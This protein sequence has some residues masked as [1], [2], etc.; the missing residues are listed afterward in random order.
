MA[1]TATPAERVTKRRI[2]ATTTLAITDLP[3]NRALDHKAMSA[4]RGAAL[5]A[6]NWVLGAFRPF[7]PPILPVVNF[8]QTNYF[9]DQLNLQLQNIE[10]KNSGSGAVTVDALQNALNNISGAPTPPHP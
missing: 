8:Y 7:T 10:V 6:G 5:G 1:P 3:S 4:I 9:A 2:M